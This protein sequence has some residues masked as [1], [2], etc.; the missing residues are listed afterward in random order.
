MGGAFLKCI[1]G[2]SVYWCNV[3]S[4]RD[5]IHQLNNHRETELGTSQTHLGKQIVRACNLQVATADKAHAGTKFKSVT[6]D[7]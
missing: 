5:D 7:H 4:D 6:Q 2:K 1:G 3:T